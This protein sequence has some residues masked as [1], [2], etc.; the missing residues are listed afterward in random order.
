MKNIEL[1]K[2]NLSKILTLACNKKLMSRAEAYYYLKL[3][4]YVP[5]NMEDEKYCY[6]EYERTHINHMTYKLVRMVADD[7]N[8]N[9]FTITRLAC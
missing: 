9:E 6:P 7:L 5:Q 1:K 8:T 3:D 4:E 2:I